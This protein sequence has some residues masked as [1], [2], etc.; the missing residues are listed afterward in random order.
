MN[1]TRSVGR[2]FVPLGIVALAGLLHSP[3]TK[4]H[5]AES[6]TPSPTAVDFNRQIRPILSE[7]CF[8]CHGP[9]EK[10]RKAKLRLDTKEGAFAKLRGGNFALVPGK[11]A[12]SELIA[13]IT[14]EDPAERM[15][16]AKSNKHLT[17]QQVAL[18]KQWVEQGA[19]WNEHWS[20]IP[21]RR[22]PI[23]HVGD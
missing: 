6:K 19:P 4:P 18:L 22:P 11:P 14:A 8:A 16:P 1:A 5:A 13:R 9:D 20:F 15:P 17:P 23:P 3:V 21:P 10:Q 12:E 2:L 7:N